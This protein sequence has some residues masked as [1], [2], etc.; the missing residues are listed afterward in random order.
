M[1]LIASREKRFKENEKIL[2]SNQGFKLKFPSNMSN[3][4]RHLREIFEFY[5]QTV[6]AEDLVLL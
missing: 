1:K 6:K 2:L 3:F 5:K 4:P